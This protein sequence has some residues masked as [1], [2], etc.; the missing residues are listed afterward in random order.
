MLALEYTTYPEIRSHL[1]HIIKSSFSEL[2]TR[3][4]VSTGNI[5]Y[6]Q[7]GG[8]VMVKYTISHTPTYEANAA[9]IESH[10]EFIC[11][12]IVDTILTDIK[13]INV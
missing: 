4:K 3:N 13:L 10:I 7:C 8:G 9:G 2:H 1:V 11:V 6:P 12:K 5:T